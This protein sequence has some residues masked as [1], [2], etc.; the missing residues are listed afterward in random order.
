LRLPF[1]LMLNSGEQL[2]LCF[3]AAINFIISIGLFL[4]LRVRISRMD[5]D[6]GLEVLEY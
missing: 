1:A 5:D 3:R 2:S 6:L 4:R